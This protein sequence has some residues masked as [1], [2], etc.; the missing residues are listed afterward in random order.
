MFTETHII[1]SLQ[2]ITVLTNTWQQSIRFY[3]QALG[4]QI[5]QS[6][7]I[8]EKQKEIFG[9]KLGQYVLLGHQEGSVIRLIELEDVYAEPNR[10]GANP[11]DNGLCV[12]EAGTPDVDQAYWRVIR[13]KFGAIAPPTQFDCE[14]PEP[15]GYVLMKSTAFIGPSGEQIFVTQIVDRKGGV[16][17]LKEKAIDGINTPANAVISLKD[18]K[19]QAFYNEVL[20]IYPINDLVLKQKGAAAIMAGPSDMGF[21]MCLMG[22]GTERIGMEQHIYEPHNENYEYKVFPNDFKKTGI[23][24]ATWKGINLERLKEK[25]I[26]KGMTI[27]SE[28]GLPIIGNEEPKAIVFRGIVGEVLELIS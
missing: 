14:G 10:I 26:E 22:Y 7:K 20:G 3:C 25:L 6:G 21:D 4:Y 5:R 9:A 2:A 15:L 19:Q 13:N 27:I 12:M 1:G 23:V 8:S 16:S 17:L 11:Y 18:R 24:C 28:I